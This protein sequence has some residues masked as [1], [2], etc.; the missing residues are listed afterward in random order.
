MHELAA[1][2][3]ETVSGVVATVTA[4][5]EAVRRNAES[6]TAL[7]GGAIEETR[8]VGGASDKM[9]GDVQTVA[10]ATEELTISFAEV[11]R[12]VAEASQIAREAVGDAA[13]TSRCIAALAEAAQQIGGVVTLIQGVAKQTNLLALNA[14][15]EASRAGEAGRGF[16]VVA[17]EVKGLAGQTAKAT[18]EIAAQIASVQS[19]SQEA[20]AAI[21][22]IVSTIER[23]D[24]VS[25]AMS[26]AIEEQQ[27]STRE[28][29]R[30]VQQAAAETEQ[31][32]GNVGNLAAAAR[33]TGAAADAVLGAARDLAREA[34]RLRRDVATFLEKVRA[35]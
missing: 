2:F 21:S 30:S 25:T 13:Q 18:E 7:A 8:A 14:T 33:D 15:I 29:A 6:M 10:A 20:V 11:G 17:N 5:S 4:A 27:S 35:A 19:A 26:A 16:A 22:R 12:S 1:H 32:S 28:I 24:G 3:E 31:V 9:T 34:D 23:M